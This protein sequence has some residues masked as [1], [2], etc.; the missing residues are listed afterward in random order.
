MINEPDARDYD[1]LTHNLRIMGS[2]VQP[3]GL[4]DP[5][6][7]RISKTEAVPKI[8]SNIGLREGKTT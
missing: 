8:G 3:G 1:A 6:R 2:H 5:S 7:F 4:L